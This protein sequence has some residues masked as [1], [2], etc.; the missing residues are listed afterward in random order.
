M[1]IAAVGITS[2]TWMLETRVRHGVPVPIRKHG[3]TGEEI[4]S[5]VQKPRYIHLNVQSFVIRLR[6]PQLSSHDPVDGLRVQ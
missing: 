3:S 6:G 2:E 1:R 4:R 5:T